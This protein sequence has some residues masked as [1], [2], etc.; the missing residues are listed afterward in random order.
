MSPS[1][2]TEVENLRRLNS[3]DFVATLVA[4]K[5]GWDEFEGAVWTLAELPADIRSALRHIL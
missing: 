1:S 2:Q 3:D 4:K 5:Y